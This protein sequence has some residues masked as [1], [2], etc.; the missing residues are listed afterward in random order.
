MRLDLWH[1]LQDR[2]RALESEHRLRSAGQVLVADKQ[3]QFR[4]DGLELDVHKVDRVA[5]HVRD[6]EPV[7]HLLRGDQL[8]VVD[9]EIHLN[10]LLAPEVQAVLLVAHLLEVGHQAR[11]IDL[12]WCTGNMTVLKWNNK[13][14]LLVYDAKINS[15]RPF[16]KIIF[17]LTH[18]RQR[19]GRAWS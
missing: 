6:L 11:S 10:G 19:D 3:G 4:D 5:E 9:T 16:S 8:E 15:G 17:A 12:A 1:G 2:F 13:E 18:Y 7:Q 14:V